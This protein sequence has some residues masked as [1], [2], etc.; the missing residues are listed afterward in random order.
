MDAEKVDLQPICIA[1]P[2]ILSHF[3]IQFIAQLK[4]EY[5]VVEVESF[6]NLLCKDYLGLD[7]LQVALNPQTILEPLLHKKLDIALKRLLDHEPIQ[8]ILG[9]TE[10]FG[11][12]FKVNSNVLIPRP[13]TEELVEWVLEDLKN[14]TGLSVLD[15]GTGSGCIAISLA[16]NLPRTKIYALDISVHALEIAKENANLNATKVEFLQTDI[17]MAKD[18]SRKFNA[19]VSN[20]PYVRELEKTHMQRNV[21]ENEPKSALYVK[22]DDALV[23]YRKIAEL[24]KANLEEKGAVYV[25]INQY[26]GKETE[27]VFQD[28]GFKTELR[29][30]IFGNDRMMKGYLPF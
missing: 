16:K 20:P 26:L 5:P 11:L 29:K 3:K 24:A 7:R 27:Q 6:F 15:I 21:L 23:F 1:F 8:Y 18:L 2:M 30:D 9:K 25:E 28:Q 19:I 10:F 14:R 17:L 12:P 13:E 4:N 22:D